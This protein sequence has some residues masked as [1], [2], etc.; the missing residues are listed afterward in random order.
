[1]PRVPR[2]KVI[3]AAGAALVVGVGAAFVAPSFAASTP[4]STV[5]QR[6]MDQLANC[7]MVTAAARSAH[8]KAWGQDCA[9]GARS[10]IDAWHSAH[11]TPRASGN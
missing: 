10:A 1:M 11:P 7:Q 3:L 9:A 4:T 6:L 2:P 5:P 8:Q